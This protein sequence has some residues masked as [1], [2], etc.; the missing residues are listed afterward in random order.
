MAKTPIFN[1]KKFI[2][3][4]SEIAQ[5][6]IDELYDANPNHTTFEQGGLVGSHEIVMNYIQPTFNLAVEHLL[7]MIHESDISYPRE[8]MLRLHE[9]AKDA[10][11]KSIYSLENLANVDSEK[12]K[13]IYNQP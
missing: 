8:R 7:F 12:L 2:I 11:I 10:G 1:L 6:L 9:Y 13:W 3:E 4:S 5:K